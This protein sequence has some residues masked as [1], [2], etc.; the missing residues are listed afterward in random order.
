MTA[1]LPGQMSIFDLLPQQ[2]IYDIP[3]EDM[4]ARI[5]NAIGVTFIHDKFYGDYR[6]KIGKCVL[7]VEYSTYMGCF[8]DARFISVG[9]SMGPPTYLGAG[10]PVDSIEEAIQWFEKRRAKFDR[11]RLPKTN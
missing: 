7:Q 5:G 2:S 3:E 10:A 1:Q 6:A 11:K 4:V 8:N 9:L